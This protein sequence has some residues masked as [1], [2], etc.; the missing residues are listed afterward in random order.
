MS[1]IFTGV[2]IYR[3]LFLI[4]ALTC[5]LNAFFYVE[6]SNK[7]QSWAR[8][9]AI[10]EEI[11]FPYWSNLGPEPSGTKYNYAPRGRYLIQSGYFT[12]AEENNAVEDPTSFGGFAGSSNNGLYGKTINYENN[13]GA[14]IDYI[15][16]NDDS[17]GITS[18]GVTVRVYE[19]WIN[20]N[21]SNNTNTAGNFIKLSNLA[22]NYLDPSIFG[23]SLDNPYIWDTSGTYAGY[24][25]S[26]HSYVS[27]NG[28]ELTLQTDQLQD[29]EFN[30]LLSSSSVVPEPST[31]ALI[32]GAIALGFA[33]SRRKSDT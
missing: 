4:F 6:F 13:F 21:V 7:L 9:A 2:R 3:L 23:A 20:V 10:G 14:D 19:Q 8:A 25:T 12:S 5:N 31:Y 22:P 33:I 1:L 32:F 28:L 15:V 16:I 11:N 24:N 29:G 17:A 27:I 30:I 18:N 26:T